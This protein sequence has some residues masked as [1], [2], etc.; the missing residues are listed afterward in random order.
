MGKVRALVVY[1]PR[2]RN[3]KYRQLAQILAA[4]TAVQLSHQIILTVR[5]KRRG[6]LRHLILSPETPSPP[7]FPPP[8]APNSGFMPSRIAS[9]PPLAVPPFHPAL[10]T[11]NRKWSHNG[12]LTIP[13]LVPSASS[14]ND[15]PETDIDGEEWDKVREMLGRILAPQ[16]AAAPGGPF[17]QIDA[18]EFTYQIVL[19]ENH[20][21]F[22]STYRCE[23][24]TG[25]KLRLCQLRP[26]TDY[27]VQLKACLE[28]RGL[29]G[30]PSQPV[31]FKTAPG[32]PEAPLMFRYVSRGIDHLV[33]A[34]R[35]PNDNGAS[36]TG[37]TVYISKPSEDVGE[38]VWEGRLCE[39]R[40]TNLRPSTSYRLRVTAVNR[41]GESP[42]APPIVV[43][44]R[45]D[46]PPP[47]PLPPNVVSV[48]ARCVKLAWSNNS[49]CTYTVE[50]HDVAAGPNA[51]TV[52]KDHVS[53]ATAQ[54]VDLKA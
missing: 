19:F 43:T 30:E 49:E 8:N 6:I 23:T 25:N 1:E 51:I 2:V 36:I 46:C 22:V 42:E 3:E 5:T 10:Y 32:R 35:P 7:R 20:G 41:I 13:D 31:C 45:S 47:A 28:E 14:R 4:V 24:E 27:Y 9:S 38:K 18:S 53:G 12:K 50:M 34:W 39:A 21:R 29:V 11:V 52:V 15:E 37:Y 54:I 17:P 16:V 33:V 44:T 48:N 40:I 26:N